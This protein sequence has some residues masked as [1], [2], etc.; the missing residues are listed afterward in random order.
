MPCLAAALKPVV[1]AN[2]RQIDTVAL[3]GMWMVY[4]GPYADSDALTRKEAELKRIKGLDFDEVHS[5]ANLSPGLSLGRFSKQEN[6][7]KALED[8]KNRGI[9][10]AR[11]ITLRAPGELVA[12]RV[13]E[14][15]QAQAAQ[16]TALKLPQGKAFAICRR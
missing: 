9:R 10:T 8:L 3:N 6:A 16:L 11:I 1:P 4:M 12:V 2:A 13:P 7:N 5:P 14:A 15:S